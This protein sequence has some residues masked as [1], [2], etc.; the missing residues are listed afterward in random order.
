MKAAHMAKSLAGAAARW[1]ASGFPLASPKAL[2]ARLDVCYACEWWD[3]QGF[4]G[5]GRCRKCG[6]STQAKLRMATSKCPLG[7]W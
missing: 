5:T 6:C 3:A 1:A 4:R 2:A 7:K